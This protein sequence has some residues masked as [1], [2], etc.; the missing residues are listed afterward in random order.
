MVEKLTLD[1]N[2]PRWEVQSCCLL[3]IDLKGEDHSEPSSLWALLFL[4]YKREPVSTPSQS[5]CEELIRKCPQNPTWPQPTAAAPSHWCRRE[6]WRVS[7][8]WRGKPEDNQDGMGSWKAQ[9]KRVSRRK[10][11]AIMSSAEERSGQKWTTKC[12]LDLAIRRSLVPLTRAL[13][14]ECWGW[15]PGSGGSAV[16]TRIQVAWLPTNIS[17][18]FTMPGAASFWKFPF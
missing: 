6:A 7:E 18:L 2:R 10:E 17:V 15:E 4:V 3:A 11:W 5:C 8:E 1:S 16:K 13:G 14:V 12:P 9:S